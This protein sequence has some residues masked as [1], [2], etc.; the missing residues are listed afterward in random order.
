MVLERA[1]RGLER[2]V[3]SDVFDV[4]LKLSNSAEVT[5]VITVGASAL[6]APPLGEGGVH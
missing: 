3:Q 2:T 1:Q 6:R 5:S 4:L